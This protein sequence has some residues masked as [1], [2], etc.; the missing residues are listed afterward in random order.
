M[1]QNGFGSADF[2]FADKSNGFEFRS[3]NHRESRGFGSQSTSFRSRG[4]GTAAPKPNASPSS[5]SVGARV[6]HKAF[7][8]GMILSAKPMG[9]D[10]LLEIAFDQ[11]G[12]KKLM[13]NFARLE[14]L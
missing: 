8:E 2:R 14:M 10:T 13:A 9:N 1:S 11:K 5:Y 6:K 4:I 3:E 7:G 12:T